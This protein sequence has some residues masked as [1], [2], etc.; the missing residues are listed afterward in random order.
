MSVRSAGDCGFWRPVVDALGERLG[1]DL[2]ARLYALDLGFIRSVAD[3]DRSRQTRSYLIR[4]GPFVKWVDLLLDLGADVR[5][6]PGLASYRRM[7][8]HNALLHDVLRTTSAGAL[9]VESS[10]GFRYGIGQYQ[11]YPHSARFVPLSRDGRGVMASMMRSGRSREYAVRQWVNYYTQALKWLERRV[12]AA[13]VM[14]VRYEELAAAPRDVLKRLEAFCGLPAHD[15]PQDMR[16]ATDQHPLDGNP[17]RKAAPAAIRLDE[18]WRAELSQDDLR[19]FG[20][21]AAAI[22]RRLGYSEAVTS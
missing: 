19:Y 21:T 5:T 18:R 1:V 7:V 17:M 3:V 10:K 20:Q 14:R 11:I 13:D 2:W 8:E 15:W 22:C 9:V 4:R 16:I 6:G 12:D